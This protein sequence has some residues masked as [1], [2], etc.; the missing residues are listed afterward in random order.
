M[1]QSELSDLFGSSTEPSCAVR[2]REPE[3]VTQLTRRLRLLIEGSFAS[4]WVEGE[5]SNFRAHPSGH[6]YFTLKDEGAQIAAAMFRNANQRVQFKPAD[7][8]KVIVTGSV[9]VYEP[10][11]KYQIVCETM[12]PGGIGALQLAFEQLKRKLA[13]EGLFDSARKKRL[14]LLPHTIGV[15]TSPSGAAIRDIVNIILR[16]FPTMHIVLVPVQVQGE[17]AAQQIAAAIDWCNEITRKHAQDPTR[18]PLCFDVL[19]VGRG[20]GSIEDLWA[21]NEEVVAR[22]IARSAIPIISAVGHETDYTIA[23]FVADLRAPTPS[24][25]AELVVQPREV[26]VGRVNETRRRAQAA[27][28]RQVQSVQRRLDRIMTHYALREPERIILHYSQ[29]VDELQNA[30]RALMSERMRATEARVAA[31][32]QVVRSARTLFG[33]QLEHQ[34]HVLRLQRVALE[35]AMEH[36]LARKRDAL[37]RLMAQMEALGPVAVLRRGY[38]IT[39]AAE[40]GLPITSVARVAPGQALRTQFADGVADS[41]VTLVRPAAP[42]E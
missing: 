32:L 38:T 39:R 13:A 31:A 21:F 7:G 10:Q 34:S 41:T 8:L 42:R 26:L 18:Y 11:G 20:G 19:I 27:L 1:K 2:P 14:P 9:Q 35:T 37:L 5:I 22:A 12:E 28:E 15:V 33:R 36:S 40:T 29:R 24:A 30:A 17:G 3:T 16:R 4:V 25:A 6:W 23:D